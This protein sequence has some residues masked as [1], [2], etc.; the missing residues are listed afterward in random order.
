MRM[1]GKMMTAYDMYPL[2][3]IRFSY[4]KRSVGAHAASSSLTRRELPF[5]H[6]DGAGIYTEV[7][8]IFLTF[9]RFPHSFPPK[10]RPFHLKKSF[11]VENPMSKIVCIMSFPHMGKMLE[12]G[13]SK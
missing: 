8:E 10:K 3:D 5:R 2:S 11:F 13:L 9:H 6:A 1:H 12:C 4:E 7:H